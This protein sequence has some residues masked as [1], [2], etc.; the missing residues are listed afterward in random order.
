M[1]GITTRS[2]SRRLAPALALALLAAAALALVVVVDAAAAAP[3]QPRGEVVELTDGNFD[4][5]TWT[6]VW[7]IDVYAVWCVCC[8]VVCASLATP[9]PCQRRRQERKPARAIRRSS[10]TIVTPTT[11]TTTPNRRRPKKVQALPAAGADVARARRRGRQA[12]RA[13][14]KG[15]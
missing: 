11:L 14:R 8:W 7:M 6:G 5:E 9:R 2:S 15:D 12:R 1:A 10:D 3:K 4:Q 13:R